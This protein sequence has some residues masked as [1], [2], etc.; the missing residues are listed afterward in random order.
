[1]KNNKTAEQKLKDFKKSNLE[2]RKY[3]AKKAGSPSV[4]GHFV[5]LVWEC[6]A[7]ER[8]NKEST[9]VMKRG[10]NIFRFIRGLFGYDKN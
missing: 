4:E 9:T 10:F 3:L 5:D 2:R 8:A 1:M 6:K 7:E